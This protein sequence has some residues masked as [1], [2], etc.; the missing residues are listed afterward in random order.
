MTKHILKIHLWIA[1]IGG[2]MILTGCKLEFGEE[3]DSARAGFPLYPLTNQL[4]AV[5][6]RVKLTVPATDRDIRLRPYQQWFFNGFPLDAQ[7]ADALGV[8]GYNTSTL[9][10]DQVKLINCGFYSYQNENDPQADKGPLSRAFSETSELLV[11]QSA[12]PVQPTREEKELA[13]IAPPLGCVVYGT[14]VAG[15]GGVNGACPGKYVGYVEYDN[16][17]DPSE[18]WYLTNATLNGMAFDNN[19]L[20]HA[21]TEVYY[22]GVP[23]SNWACATNIP[24]SKYP[25]HFRIYF[26]SG[27]VPS[28]AYGLTLGN[29]NVGAPTPGAPGPSPNP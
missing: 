21:N 15:A 3:T 10:I 7:S 13:A 29:F 12:G 25:Y 28:G 14:P 20:T 23:A 18:G 17:N 16:P 11:V 5:N 8:K 2:V 9:S 24:A 6:G 4:A 19:L 22:I 26:K 1:A 27:S